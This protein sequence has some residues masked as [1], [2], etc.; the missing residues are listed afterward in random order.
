MFAMM[1]AA[2]GTATLTSWTVTGYVVDDIG[3]NR[4][5]GR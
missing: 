1:F 3:H 5:T 2:T 4:L